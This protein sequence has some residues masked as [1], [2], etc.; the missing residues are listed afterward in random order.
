MHVAMIVVG[1][2][3]IIIVI[4]IDLQEK[5]FVIT[6]QWLCNNFYQQNVHRYIDN[7]L[8]MPLISTYGAV[9]DMGACPG[10]MST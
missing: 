5:D 10:D 6:Q 7:T 2:D 4:A 8:F 1:S 9:V 3:C